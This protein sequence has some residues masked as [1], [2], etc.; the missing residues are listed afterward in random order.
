[1]GGA[2]PLT[3]A[4]LAGFG[5][6]LLA[7][8][9]LH[10]AVRLGG[11][12]L[13]GQSAAV[14]AGAF[15]TSSWTPELPLLVAVACAVAVTGLAGWLL[16]RLASLRLAGDPAVATWALGWLALT[17]VAAGL[18]VSTEADLAIPLHLVVPA[19]GVTLDLGTTA[20]AAVAL[21]LAGVCVLAVRRAGS[22]PLAAQLALLR[23]SPEFAASLGLPVARLR[24]GAL[25]VGCALGA[26]AGAGYL[27]LQGVTGP[28]DVSPTLSIELLAAVL[29]GSRRWWGIPAG[30][31]AL[32]VLVQVTD[33]SIASA[34]LIVAAGVVARRTSAIAARPAAPAAEVL[35]PRRSVTPG[36]GQLRRLMDLRRAGGGLVVAGLRASLG[37]RQILAGVDL[38]VAPGEVH[39]LIGPNGAGKTTALRAIAGAVGSN[40][41]VTVGGRTLLPGERRRLAGG[42]VRTLQSSPDT[43][44]LS[45]VAVVAAAVPGQ[46]CAGLRHLIAAGS[47]RA[48]LDRRTRVAVE[49]LRLVGFEGASSVDARLLPLACAHAT[50]AAVIAMDE[51]AA[52]VERAR[53]TAAIRAVADS[54][55]TVLL[56]EH[57]LRLVREVADRASLLLEGRVAATGAVPAIFDEAL[58]RDAYLGVTSPGV[59]SPGVTAGGAAA[60]G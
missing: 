17:S 29:V 11:I 33:P 31:V 26:L 53:I 44:G 54:G 46:R 27:T 20:E 16:G 28:T 50:G 49:A 7:V 39:A 19:G 58:V 6:L 41:A 48:E 35:D 36:G 25:G 57:D 3:L 24:A 9:G 52:G 10:I 43:L 55:R 51:P 56:V 42:V 37:G 22:G 2:L 4:G 13:L 59:P 40:G 45:P 23:T 12:P 14:A 18:F 15:L 5:W 30:A 8:A 32:E 47:S 1:M 34:L 38:E 21:L 60:R